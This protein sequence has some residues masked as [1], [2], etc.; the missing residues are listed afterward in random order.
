VLV[1]LTTLASALAVLGSD[2][3]L[4]GYRAHYQDAL[5][6][7]VLYAAVQ[8]VIV[9]E[10]ARDG[11]LVPWLAVTKAVVAY[12]FLLNFFALWP[13][14]ET[15]TPAR[16]VY[17]LFEWG[18]ERKIALFGMIFLGR[19]AFNTVNAVYF[20][21][22]WWLRLRARRPLLGRLV[23]MVPVAATAF[24]AWTF[25]QLASEEVKTFS[26]EATDVA[27]TVLAGLDCDAVRANDGRTTTD[28]RAR[29]D[30]RYHVR[31]AWGCATTRVLVLTEDGKAGTAAAPRTD[32]CPAR[33]ES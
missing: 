14:W 23:T 17:Q 31:I 1:A 11:R 9:V 28:L 15:W 4:P 6:F 3:L 26:A 30:R 20:T 18:E 16:Y 27:R 2:V 21:A 10:F 29:G 32:C 8:V 19:G 33:P 12:L 22:P 25:I 5:W 13:R 7:V 24:F